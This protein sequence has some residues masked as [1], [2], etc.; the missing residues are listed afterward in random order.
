MF[1]RLGKRCE[2]CP[3]TQTTYNGKEIKPWETLNRTEETEKSN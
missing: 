3:M 1:A 2:L